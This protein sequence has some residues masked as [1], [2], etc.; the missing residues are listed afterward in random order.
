[1]EMNSPF[2]IADRYIALRNQYASPSW[3]DV[4]MRVNEL[5]LSPFI[6]LVLLLLRRLDFL[7]GVSACLGAYT[8]WSQWIEYNELRFQV[9]SMYLVTMRTG[10]PHIVTNDPTYLPYVYADAVVR[11]DMRHRGSATERHSAGLWRHTH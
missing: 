6:A 10:G 11:H 4:A 1:M 2:A 9:Q 7:S 3:G 8:A 5:I